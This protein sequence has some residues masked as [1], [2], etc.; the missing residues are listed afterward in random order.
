MSKYQPDWIFNL[1][2][3][4]AVVICLGI[5]VVALAMDVAPLTALWRSS[6]AFATFALL[7]RAVSVIWQMPAP[8]EV[9]V[10]AE[11]EAVGENPQ[12]TES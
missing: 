12:P 1:A 5:L 9:S 10:E 7:G 8:V 2:L 4:I 3:Q 6:L 11:T